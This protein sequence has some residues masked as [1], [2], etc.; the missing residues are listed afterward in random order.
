MSFPSVNPTGT[1]AWKRLS[2]LK[3]SEQQRLQELFKTDPERAERY[4]FQWQDFY[5]DCSK[6]HLTETVHKAL[7]DLAEEV[8]LKGAIAAQFSGEH[9]NQTEDRAVMHTALR[10]FSDMKPE[11]AEVLAQMKSFSNAVISG[12]WK[13]HTGKS[14]TDVVNIGIGG[15]DLGPDMV[16]EALRNQRNHLNVHFVSNVEGDH[17]VESLKGLDPET[18]LFIIV[19]KSFTTQETLMNAQTIRKWFLQHAPE[20]QIAKHF[21]AVSTNIPAVKDFGIDPNNIFTMWDWVGG[22]FSL[23]SAVGLSIACA[24]GYEQ[25]E[26]LLRGAHAMDQHFTQTPFEQ[27]LPVTLALISIWYNNFLGAES[28]AVIPYTQY[29]T[30]LVPYL[31]Q[32]IMESNGKGVDR[33]GDV[34]DYQTGTIV[35]GST[36]TNAQHAFFQLIHQGTKVIP[37]DFI[38]F[39][40]DQH[41]QKSHQD[42]LM[43]NFIAQTQALMTGTDGQ[44]LD[45][46]FKVFTG[47]RPTN[48]ILIDQLSPNSLG[49]LIA[50][51]EHK[52]FTQGV[53]W[54]I[55]SYDQWGVQLG[56][57]LAKN[58]LSDIESGSVSAG[59]DSSTAALLNKLAE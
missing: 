22:R 16:V 56:K 35:W 7:L 31:Q 53:I 59:H 34:I 20:D 4:S 39:K 41:N 13:G 10:N 29:L 52:L 14:I 18:T 57:V 54:N 43:A 15:S 55:F 37:A 27:N 24:I 6:T 19:S 48:T 33:N 47:D 12:D 32:A 45:S 2:E 30:K 46:P 50:L 9:I 3:A 51:Y 5:V 28:E 11:V 8:D 1:N 42:A 40:K 49:K 44:T 23:W 26:E 17:V 25:Y 38:G 58:T 21:V 36:G